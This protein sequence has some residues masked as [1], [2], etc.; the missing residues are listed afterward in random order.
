[1]NSVIGRLPLGLSR[2]G[3]VI[4][5]TR[6][7][8]LDPGVLVYLMREKELRFRA[9]RAGSQA[10]DGTWSRSMKANP[11]GILNMVKIDAACCWA[12]WSVPFADNRER[13]RR[14]EHYS[15]EL[16]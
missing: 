1:M 11:K 6:C 4:M 16:L 14:R 7:G 5:G 8:D 15:A 13:R 3:G 9:S 10:D 12:L 2:T